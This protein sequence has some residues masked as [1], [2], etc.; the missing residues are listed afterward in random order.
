MPDKTRHLIADLG[1]TCHMFWTEG[2]RPGKRELVNTLGGVTK[3]VG[4]NKASATIISDDLRIID[5]HFE[6]AITS[7][8]F[9]ENLLSLMQLM[10]LRTLSLE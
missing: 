8:E 9:T 5:L 1:A 6:Y 2:M 10:G 7:P 4:T 3:G